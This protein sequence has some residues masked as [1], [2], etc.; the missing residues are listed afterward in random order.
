MVFLTKKKELKKKENF[1][2]GNVIGRL[3][4]VETEKSKSLTWFLMSEQSRREVTKRE[5]SI[6]KKNLGG[7]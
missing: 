7:F 5:G 3:S 4:A 1:I 6:I 2:N